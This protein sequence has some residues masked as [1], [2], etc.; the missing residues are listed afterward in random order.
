MKRSTL[1]IIAAALMLSNASYAQ[2]SDM[3]LPSS[4]K[5]EGNTRLYDF[6]FVNTDVAA[7]MQALAVTAGVDIVPSPELPGMKIDL[8]ITKKTWQEA[9]DI[10]CA[11]YDLTWIIEDKYISVLKTATWQA[12]QMKA[13]EKKEQSEQ[14]APLVRKN[15][16]IKH[17]KAADLVNVLQ[18]MVSTRGRLTVVDRNNAIIVY[19]NAVRIGQ[20]EKALKELDVETQQIIISAKLVYLTKTLSEELGTNWSAKSAAGKLTAGGTTP[21]TGGIYN[22]SNQVAASS[23]PAGVTP[24]ALLQGQTISMSLLNNNLGINIYDLI[25][26]GK[27]E[28]IASPEI[29][30]LDNVQATIF[31]GDEIS[32]RVIDATG[33]AA[34]QLINSGIQLTVTPHVTGDN[35]ILL[36]LKPENNSW[37]YDT[38]GNPVIS[39]QN[40]QTNVV[41]ADGE[42]VVIGGLTRNEVKETETGIPLLKDIPIFG[43]LFKYKTKAVD[44]KDLVIFVTPRIQRSQMKEVQALEETKDTSSLNEAPVAQPASLTAPAA[45]Q[46]PAVVPAKPTIQPAVVA[47][48]VAPQAAPQPEPAATNT[49]PASPAVPPSK[50]TGGADDEWK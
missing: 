18:S 19:D 22:P 40:A 45:Q 13:A 16:Q 5:P 33:Q 29:S 15:F 39:K 37:S 20:M 50:P 43:Y 46:A 47:P 25:G 6:N 49:P 30:T 28:I 36:E 4:S 1:F 27:G 38:K 12:K 23:L 26:D 8:K 34:T 9:L 42:T 44:K 31:M 35:R 32:L 48:Q 2:V 11:T 24:D 14:V 21:S 17:A 10:V 7:V 3:P 41:V